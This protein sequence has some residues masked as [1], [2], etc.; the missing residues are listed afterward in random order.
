MDKEK[1]KVEILI[2]EIDIENFK[3]CKQEQHQF[4]GKNVLITGRNK[5]GK[6]TI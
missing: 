5:A 1:R 2:D 3:G 4:N 6:S